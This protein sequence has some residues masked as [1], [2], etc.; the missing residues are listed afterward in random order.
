MIPSF[1]FLNLFPSRPHPPLFFSSSFHL[2]ELPS[3]SPFALP[4]CRLLTASSPSSIRRLGPAAPEPSRALWP[5]RDWAPT[6]SLVLPLLKLA[7]ANPNTACRQSHQST[8]S[9]PLALLAEPTTSPHR[10]LPRL[11]LSLLLHLMTRPRHSSSPIATPALP[12]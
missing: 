6:F 7:E 8:L 12:L 10:T 9:E 3:S 4:P 5:R 11:V 1:F 2:S